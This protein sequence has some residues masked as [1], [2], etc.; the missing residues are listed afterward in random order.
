MLTISLRPRCR[1]VAETA[2]QVAVTISR[3]TYGI[4]TVCDYCGIQLFQLRLST[5]KAEKSNTS[6]KGCWESLT[7]QWIFKAIPMQQPFALVFDFSALL[8]DN[9]NWNSCIRRTTLEIVEYYFALH[10]P[11][12]HT[13]RLISFQLIP[14]ISKVN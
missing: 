7:N 6:A 12:Y 13:I 9:L 2:L 3:V 5:S 8:V 10:K 11:P 1:C 14:M 4:N